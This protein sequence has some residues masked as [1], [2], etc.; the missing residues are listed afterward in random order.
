VFRIPHTNSLSAFQEFSFSFWINSTSV[1]DTES[2]WIS[3]HSGGVK[4]EFL[5]AALSTNR[6]RWTL[7]N[8]GGQRINLDVNCARWNDGKW[9]HVAGSFNGSSMA[10]WLDNV[11]VGNSGFGGPL[12]S[13]ESPIIIGNYEFLRFGYASFQYEG[14]IDEV[15]IWNRAISQDEVRQI[16][17]QVRFQ[18]K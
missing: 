7:V 13:Y 6:I 16:Y 8:R 18:L 1:V 14:L 9:H 17:D 2:V 11:P 12:N 15:K 3:K 5:V 4:G 10:L